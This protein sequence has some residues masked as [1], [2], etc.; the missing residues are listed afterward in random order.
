MKRTTKRSSLALAAL[1]MLY[2]APMHPYRMQ[3]LIKER[4][5]DE[6]I[7]V[8]QRASLYQT[9]GRLERDGLIRAQKMTRD[10]NRPE[11]TLYELTDTGRAITLD[12][13]RQILST[14]TQ[15]FPEFPAAISFL[16]LLTPKD[17]LRQLEVR[18]L[19]LKAEI[20]RID[21]QCERA[22]AVPRLFLLEM[23]LLRATYE[24]ERTWV[25]SVIKDLQSGALTWSKPWLR[26]VAAE[27]ARQQT[28]A[29]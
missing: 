18:T 26:K 3:K 1:A 29:E 13:M 14:P 2:E 28:E 24:T 10:E 22:S 4:G 19:A 8:G 27:F 11:R 6:V 15:E 25:A 17:A 20:E 5:K 12:W 23:E 7:N 21:Q 16:P 9:I